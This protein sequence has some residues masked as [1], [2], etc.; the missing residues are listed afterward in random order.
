M[1]ITVVPLSQLKRPDKNVR[2]HPEKQIQEMI[3]SIQMFGTTRPIV[4]DENFT[5]LAGNG[6]LTALEAMN[7]KEA[8]CYIVPNLTENQKKKLMLADNRIYKLGIDDTEAF[9]AIIAELGQDF[10]VPGFDESLLRMLNTTTEQADALFSGYGIVTDEQKERFSSASEDYRNEEAA[11]AQ[12][13]QPYAQ[14]GASAPLQRPAQAI[15]TVE[16][17]EQSAGTDRAET[18]SDAPQ[19]TR[20]YIICPKCGERIWV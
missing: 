7:A 16:P 4:C 10:D 12:S 14:D 15:Q 18:S 5:V 1:K 19:M 3:R 2:I 11:F 17:M 8:E 9:D 13:A 6:L 20:N